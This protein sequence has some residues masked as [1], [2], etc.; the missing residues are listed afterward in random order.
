MIN[1]NNRKTWKQIVGDQTLTDEEMCEIYSIVNRNKSFPDYKCARLAYIVKNKIYK[2][3]NMN[4]TDYY[5]YISNIFR[6][7]TTGLH[8]QYYSINPK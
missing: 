3:H 6:F 2:E 7:K 8:E 4:I 1:I 5:D